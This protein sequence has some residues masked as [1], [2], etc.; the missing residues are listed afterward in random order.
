MSSE[1]QQVGEDKICICIAN[2][3]MRLSKP[4]AFQ[5]TFFP[6]RKKTTAY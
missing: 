4:E 1:L 3:N 6:S 2:E 5:N